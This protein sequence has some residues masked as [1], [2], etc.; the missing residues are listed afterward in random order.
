MK[1][2]S[3]ELISRNKKDH[4]LREG[5]FEMRKQQ[6]TVLTFLLV[7][8]FLSSMAVEAATRFRIGFG[9]KTGIPARRTVFVTHVRAGVPAHYHRHLYPPQTRIVTIKPQNAGRVDFNVN[10]SSSRIYVDGT[11]IG[12]ADDY[13]GGLFGETATLKAGKHRI[14][15]VSPDERVVIRDIYVMP[16]KELDFNLTF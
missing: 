15:V 3:K 5:G 11:Y 6:W 9:F 10:P 7:I 13:N 12:V 8:L 4:G 16:G 2:S 14:K 1:I